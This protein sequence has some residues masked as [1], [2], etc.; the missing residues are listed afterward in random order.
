[1]EGSIW[2]GGQPGWVSLPLVVPMKHYSSTQLSFATLSPSASTHRGPP[3]QLQHPAELC[4]SSTCLPLG[5]PIASTP[6]RCVLTHVLDALFIRQVTSFIQIDFPPCHSNLC[7]APGTGGQMEHWVW[8]WGGGSHPGDR[9][10][11]ALH[12][13]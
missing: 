7:H 8:R 3:V 6:G 4:C 13:A 2:A 1:M 5:L 9:T 12:L 11:I 10:G